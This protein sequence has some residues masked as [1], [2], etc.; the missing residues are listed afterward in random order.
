MN[1]MTAIPAARFLSPR[2]GFLIAQQFLRR[3]FHLLEQPSMITGLFDGRLQFL[4]Q[5][6]QAFE[7]L[8]VREIL[9][10]RV[11]QGHRCRRILCH[12]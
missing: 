6:R 1:D 9:V 5:L 4:A 8:L 3:L 12:W 7:A 2:L 11:F 10:Q